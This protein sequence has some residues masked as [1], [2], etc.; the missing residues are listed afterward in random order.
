[1]N[2]A[3]PAPSAGESPEGLC[4]VGRPWR[5]L[6]ES[7]ELQRV[8]ATVRELVAPHLEAASADGRAVPAGVL[9]LTLADVGP[10]PSAL[11]VPPSGEAQ[12]EEGYR[13][14][15]E[16]DR[17]LCQARTPEGVFRAAV[18]ALHL[19]VAAPPEGLAC[20][21]SEESP[22]YAW[23]GLM[24][25]PARHFLPVGELRKIIDLAALYKLNVLHLHLTDNEGWRIEIPGRPELTAGRPHY[26]VAEYRELQAYAA[27]RFVTVVPEIDLPG[28]SAAA[29]RAYPMLGTVGLP[30]WVPEGAPFAPPLDPR[31][32]VTRAFV[33]EVL[34]EVARATTGAFIHFGGDEALGM[35]G[36]RFTEAV[37]LARE[38]I[39]ACGKQ[40]LG[41]Q[42]SAR[43]GIGPG[44][45][46]QWWVDVPMMEL[47]DSDEELALRPELVKAGMTMPI[48][49]ALAGVFASTDDDLGRIVDGGARVLL[50]PQSHLYLDR[51]YDLAVVPADRHEGAERLG[52][53]YRPRDLR[54]AAAWDPTAYGLAP[55]QVAGIEA[56]LFGETIKNFDDLTTLLLP[57]LAGVAN[58]AWTG[59][60]PRW[61]EYR[62]RLAGQARLW[63]ERG[64]TALLSTEVDWR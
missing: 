46:A 61:E 60:V 39:R 42:E 48:V 12:P 41:W 37:V 2:A 40:P 11:G 20:G 23:R 47:P 13:L 27:E 50:S 58:V 7:Q 14:T 35:D 4:P 45:I 6:T 29:L 44:E 1:M 8:A 43:A 19:L 22:R 16:S 32:E 33:T 15:V 17:I 10:A 18:S 5:V 38:L 25:D 57:R 30:A 31:D 21:W 52:F 24:V 51:P 49:R 64:V 9:R 53:A 56:T 59:A 36:E 26:T 28:H 54:Y 63:R 55:E 3:I 62:E 34:T